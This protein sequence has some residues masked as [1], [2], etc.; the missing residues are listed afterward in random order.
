MEIDLREEPVCGFPLVIG[1]TQTIWQEAM[2]KKRS[3]Y[4]NKC[5]KKG[6]PENLCRVAVKALERSR[7]NKGVVI[8][9]S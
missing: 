9:E 4:C 7:K 3:F 1:Q 2:Y 5:F 8:R 6:H